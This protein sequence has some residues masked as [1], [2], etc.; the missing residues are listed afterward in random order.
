MEYLQFWVVYGSFPVILL[1]IFHVMCSLLKKIV[2]YLRTLTISYHISSKSTW[3]HWEYWQCRETRSY[4]QGSDP[5]STKDVL[6][7]AVI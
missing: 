4:L 5:V 3:E 6:V 7:V 1:F 2:S